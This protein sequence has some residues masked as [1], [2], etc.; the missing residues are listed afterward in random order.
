MVELPENCPKC[1]VSLEGEPIPERYLSMYG[2]KTR[3]SRAIGLYDRDRDRTTH[4]QCPDCK[5]TWDRFE[6]ED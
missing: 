2:G 5:H 6:T 4:W 1:G 3:F